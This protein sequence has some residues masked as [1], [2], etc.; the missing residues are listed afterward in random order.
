M[1]KSIMELGSLIQGFKFICQTE[2]K[3]AKTID[4]YSDFLS[5][6]HRFLER[7]N[8]PTNITK[9]DKNHVREFIRYLQTEAKTPRKLTPLTG[10]TIQ[11]Y[12][13]SL[14]ALFSWAILNVCKCRS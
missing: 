5:R 3:S 8:M 13:R 12:V 2:G 6:F 7:S 10:A 9:I 1:T 14:K 4:W 11:G